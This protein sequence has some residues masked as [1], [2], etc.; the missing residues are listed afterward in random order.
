[1]EYGSVPQYVPEPAKPE[2][3]GL[4]IAALVLGILSLC[5]WFIPLCGFPV[6]I[7]GVVLGILGLKNSKKG[8]AIAGL[9]MAGI[10]LLLVLINAIFGA[11]LSSGMLDGFIPPEFKQY[12]P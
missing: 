4:S 12:M 11:A 2:K 3:Q 7:A 6:S 5:A 8:M 10:G 1:M 9:I